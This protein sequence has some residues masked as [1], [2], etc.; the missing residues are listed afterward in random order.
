MPARCTSSSGDPVALLNA[1]D[2]LYLGADAAERAFRG[3]VRAWPAAAPEDI[4]LGLFGAG[5]HAGG[6]YHVRPGACFQDTAASTPAAVGDPVGCLLDLSGN[7]NH[8]V[9]AT[10]TA[11]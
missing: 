10:S 11:R 2:A 3:G 6:M 8:L 4:V 7:G 9:Q 5:L 1:A